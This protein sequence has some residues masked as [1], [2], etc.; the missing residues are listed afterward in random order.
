MPK[1]NKRRGRRDEKKNEKKRKRREEVEAEILSK[2]QRFED[3]ADFG[4]QDEHDG[5][6]DNIGGASEIPFYGLLN[7]SEQEYFKRADEMLE[8]N[9]FDPAEERCLFLDNVYKEAD[10]KELKIANSQS[11]SRLMERLILLSTPAQL[12]NLFQKFSGHFLNL[13]Q[14]RF[15]SHCCETLFIKSAPIVTQELT[16]SLEGQQIGADG[17][18]YVSME[19]LFLFTINELE[20]NMGYLMTDRFA[21]HVLRVLLVVLSGQ[22]LATSSTAS[23]LR[24]K[25]KEKVGVLG[26]DSGAGHLG[27]E[28]RPVPEVF[29]CAIDKVVSETV[30]GLD[31]TFLR[32]LA[33][34]PTGN[35]VLQLLLELEL[36]GTDKGRAKGENSILRKLLPDQPLVEGTESASFVNGLLYDP[37]GSRLLE[38]I[39]KN[40]P[41]KI[42]KALYGNLLKTRIG[43]L[44]KNETAGFVVVRVLDRLNKQDLEEATKSILPQVSGLVERSRTVVIRSLIQRCA[45]NGVDTSDI[46]DACRL[47]LLLRVVPLTFGQVLN[48]AYG[49]VISTRLSKMLK[50]QEYQS[51]N[52]S[53]GDIHS[54]KTDP[55][56]LHGSLLVQSMLAIPGPLSASIFEGFLALPA[57]TLL[58]MTEN[59]A[60]SRVLQASLTTPTS[61]AQFKRKIIN[62]L[63]SDIGRL[64]TSVVGSHVVDA[65]WTATIG[66]GHYKDRIADEL[67]K[68]EVAMRE[69]FAG[70][71]VW[72]N[73][74]MDLFKHKKMDWVAKAKAGERDAASVGKKSGIELAREKFAATRSRNG[75]EK[76]LHADGKRK[77]QG[78]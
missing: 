57:E 22:P 3:Q 29:Q 11:C 24:S 37:V 62:S 14:H 55:E 23:L 67:L 75:A 39:V 25:K 52:I 35:P 27:L 56:Q 38:V 64:A 69:S 21:S 15:A 54:L 31:A 51:P 36:S 8:L 59:Q 61:T 16:A 33:T 26:F 76:T 60:A 71:A 32:S 48:S 17:E 66:L 10:G 30:L 47:F 12:K 49:G 63:F 78:R 74:M 1:E 34:H 53:E 7:E 4:L 19:N 65:L 43:S 2:K 13:V 72:K 20:G 41:G 28:E 77:T 44:A 73:W 70:R 68:N 40:A 50:L 46:A 45:V 18:I 6:Q 5:K 9:Q 42:F 58:S